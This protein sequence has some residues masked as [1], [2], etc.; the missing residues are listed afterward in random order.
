MSVLETPRIYFT[1]EI[2]W[3][4][5]TTNN[6]SSNYDEGAGE[7]R[8]TTVADFRHQAIEQ[9]VSR[10]NWNP[11]G[12]HRS[13]FFRTTVNGFDVGAGPRSDDPFVRQPVEFTGMLVDVEPYGGITSQLFFDSMLFGVRGGFRI[14]APRSS[15]IVAR[16]ANGN[17]NPGNAMIAGKASVVWQTSFAKEDGLVVDPFGSEVLEALAMAL[18]RDEVL[19]LTVRFNTYRT[20]YFDD[21][22]L[23]NGS[24]ATVAAGNALHGKL[25]GGG[26]QPNPTRSLVVGVLGLWGR[27]EPMQ[28]P[29]DRALLSVNP[30]VGGAYARVDGSSLV[31]DLG[32]SIQEKVDLTKRRLGTLSVVAV[33]PD[34][35]APT[36]LGLVAYEQYDRAAYES[37]A[38]IVTV[39]LP[40]GV[41]EG[42]LATQDIHVT[43]ADGTVL[44]A[45][46]PQRA[47]PLTPG[48]YLDE[49]DPG[50]AAFQVYERG[51]TVGSGRPVTLYQVST[52]GDIH[53]RW[54]LQT[55]AEGRISQPITADAG[56]I[57]S[58][59]PSFSTDD[60]P[61]QGQ[62]INP[63]VNTYMF[64]RVLP[65]DSATAALAATWENVYAHVLAN[66]NAMAPCMDNWLRLDDPAQVKAYAAVL[67]RLTDPAAFESFRFMPVTRDMSMGERTLLWT[68]LDAPD[69]DAVVVQAEEARPTFVEL[70]RAMRVR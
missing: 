54:S 34:T 24:A 44:L 65:A 32:N 25:T 23:R 64:A 11:H 7:T 68:F 48:L 3:D 6:Y 56:K 2:S 52:T 60:A 29:G 40:P 70:S 35:Q 12:T 43:M 51:R 30:A 63:Q 66:W 41:S 10:G 50:A 14:S 67:K 46:A 19:G 1:G 42:D 31:L 33:D 20:V 38:G 57:V 9:V 8:F 59:V 16:Y 62:G 69:E 49:G 53:D 17:R 15:R 4:P 26:F 58:F 13:S 47:V 61:V 18:D 22:T 55:D 36:P 21:P 28:E 45:E 27:G 37:S 39:P 5:I